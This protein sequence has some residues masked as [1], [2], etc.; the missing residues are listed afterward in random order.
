MIHLLE[1]KAPVT[2]LSQGDSDGD[3]DNDNDDN[4]SENSWGTYDYPSDWQ[5]ESQHILEGVV[6][7]THTAESQQEVGHGT[8]RV[9]SF[10]NWLQ[11][12]STSLAHNMNLMLVAAQS[13]GYQAH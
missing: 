1:P 3:N 8:G 10:P 2:K 13:N 12:R 6:P 11:V 5:E 7:T 4:A 9:I